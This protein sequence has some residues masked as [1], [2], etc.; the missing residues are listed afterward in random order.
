MKY[1]SG[2][3]VHGIYTWLGWSGEV[4][5]PIGSC[6]PIIITYLVNFVARTVVLFH[7]VL[8]SSTVPAAD[9]V[10]VLAA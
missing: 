10:L 6:V 4:A 5:E 9:H 1:V 8:D 7:A 2:R 3:I